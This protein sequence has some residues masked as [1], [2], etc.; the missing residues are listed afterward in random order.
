MAPSVGWLE[1]VGGNFPIH[2][3]VASG[4]IRP[5]DTALSSLDTG[6]AAVPLTRIPIVMPRGTSAR[7]LGNISMDK[8]G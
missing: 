5:L 1:G 7:A 8:N 6:I 3:A 4:K 2:E